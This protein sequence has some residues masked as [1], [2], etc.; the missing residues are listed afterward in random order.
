MKKILMVIYFLTLASISNA[1][2]D[3]SNSENL[4]E[5]YFKKILEQFFLK[6]NSQQD[7]V[8]ALN[9][10]SSADATIDEISTCR[11]EYEDFFDKE[12]IIFRVAFGYGDSDKIERP[13]YDLM[14]YEFF[15]RQM[16]SHCFSQNISLCGFQKDELEKN[17]YTKKILGPK[18][19]VHTIKLYVTNASY[20][21]DNIKNIGKYNHL[22]SEKTK[23]S[24][25]NFFQGAI[26]SDALFYI[27]HARNGGGP[28][29][30]YAVRNHLG[31]KDYK[32]YYQVKRPG[33]NHLLNSLKKRLT[34]IKFIGIMA[35]DSNKWFYK[36]L[37]EITPQTSFITMNG[38]GNIIDD[39]E[40]G[41]AALDSLLG[42]KC[43]KSF[44]TS[45]S[46]VRINN[47]IL[48]SAKKRAN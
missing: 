29:F 36:E 43:Q 32:N 35:C 9:I 2:A 24:E 5:R 31:K 23:E 10:C 30:K 1:F 4:N 14:Q 26:E 46:G 7:I 47:A 28:D 15:M 42:M 22:Q 6:L 27:G 37:S 20:S 19:Q 17:L 39:L 18:G 3:S 38:L 16:T 33:L 45:L 21:P 44:L 8:N 40:T 11:D 34:P 41:M 12:I 48:K 13:T 25:D